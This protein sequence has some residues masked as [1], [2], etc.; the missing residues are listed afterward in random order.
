M[1]TTANPQEVIFRARLYGTNDHVPSYFV[2]LLK[3]WVAQ[4]VQTIVV[5]SIRLTIDPLCNI[6]I[7][8]FSEPEC[9]TLVTTPTTNNGKGLIYLIIG[10]VSGVLLVCVCN[11]IIVCLVHQKTKKKRKR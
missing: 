11:V 7:N 3:N 2:Q 4:G 1:C 8:S 9:L 6:E 10:T 5:N